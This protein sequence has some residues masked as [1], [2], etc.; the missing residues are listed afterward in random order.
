MGKAHL[1]Q[2]KAVDERGSPLVLYH[3]TASEF[4][5]FDLSRVGATDDGY[6]GV[7][8]YF[9][10]DRRDASNYATMA[11]DRRFPGQ[12]ET[13][14]PSGA[15][16]IPV[17]LLVKNPYRLAQGDKG[18]LGMEPK[19]VAAWT[20][21]L[22][23]LGYDGVVNAAGNEWVVFS[24]EQ[25]MF[26]LDGC[27]NMPQASN[28]NLV[29]DDSG[30]P[31]LVYRGEHGDRANG[32]LQTRSCGY[33][34]VQEIGIARTYATCPNGVEDTADDPRVIEAQI[35]ICNPVFMSPGDPFVEF[36]EIEKKFGRPMAVTMAIRYAGQVENTGNWYENFA[37]Q[38]A[39]L[40]ELLES[41][42]E[43]L[44]QL[45]VLAWCLLDDPDFVAAARQAGYDGAI[46]CGS[47]ESACEVEYRVFDLD[48]VEVYCIHEGSAL[49]CREVLSY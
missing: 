37:G 6:M 31:L 24:P 23:M 7:G 12:K 13:D 10:T 15:R 49:S 46:H 26:F 45:Y 41:K 35:R 30:Y 42:P 21:R 19:D 25:I 22:K 14:V 2:T 9:T 40:Q 43:A 48:Q 32:V 3:G 33:T 39:G 8:I 34:F 47:G 4:R 28:K 1:S 27:P 29:V 16:V 44:A 11:S 36:S 18:T 20:E 17:Q 38:Y 5:D